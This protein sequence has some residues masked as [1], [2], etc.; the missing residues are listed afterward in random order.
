MNDNTGNR[1]TQETVEN[2]NSML[3]RVCG[4]VKQMR[5]KKDW[6]LQQLS[7]LSGVSRSMLNQI[8][9]GTANPTLGI[10]FR[11][12][13]AFG[14]TLGELVDFPESK[15]RIDVIRSG[16]ST[17]LFRDDDHC[18]IRTLS[19]VHLEKEIEFYELILKPN[20]ILDSAAHFE[21]TREFLT[22]QSGRVRL[23]SGEEVCELVA[24]DSAH[25]PADVSHKIENLAPTESI[26][27]LVDIYGRD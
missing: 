3:N 14:L 27:F 15:P 4:R 16:Q 23:T 24:G 9:R 22:I 26:A 2:S 12:A 10:A 17:H 13:Q 11:I 21:G 6:T 8:E 7:T 25:Y 18:T 5:S 20:G 19:P 1:E